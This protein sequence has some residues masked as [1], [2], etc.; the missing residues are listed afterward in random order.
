MRNSTRTKRGYRFTHDRIV[1]ENW[2][3]ANGQRYDDGPKARMIV[4]R[5]NEH[6][7]WYRQEGRTAKAECSLDRAEFESRFGTG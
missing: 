1:D 7:V 3:P 4:T 5:A 2:T 6:T